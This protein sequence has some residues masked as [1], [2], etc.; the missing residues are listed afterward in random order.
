[1]PEPEVID[2]EKEQE[3]LRLAAE[4]RARNREMKLRQ[5]KLMN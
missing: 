1:V 2:E 5:E 4:K 3:L